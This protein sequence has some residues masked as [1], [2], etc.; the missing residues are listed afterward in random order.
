ML[1]SHSFRNRPADFILFFVFGSSIFLL[2]A[3]FLGLEF[4]SPCLSAMMLYLWARRNPTVHIN[5]LEVFQFR[6]P[7]LPW[8]LLL[9]VVMFGFNPKYD[10]IG[11]AAGHIYY[12]LEDVVP[13]IPET[14][15]WKVLRA[16]KMLVTICEKMQIHDYR[17]NEED[18]I[19]EEEAVAA[20]ADENE[21]L[22]QEAQMNPGD[23]IDDNMINDDAMN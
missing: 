20:A 8:F 17:V 3:L 23:I 6:A 14:E 5:F 12:Y 16:P 7:F 19:F 1:E 10:I 9:F 11:V 2:A 21:V 22:R 15:D 13:K 4:L 18:L